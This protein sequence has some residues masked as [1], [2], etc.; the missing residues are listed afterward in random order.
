MGQSPFFGRKKK[1]CAT[2]LFYFMFFFIDNKIEA[3][4][5]YVS[6]TRRFKLNIV[7]E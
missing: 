5:E 4:P 2:I 7:V 3:Q 1:L 6:K